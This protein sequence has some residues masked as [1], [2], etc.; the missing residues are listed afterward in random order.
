MAL[1][2]YLLTEEGETIKLIISDTVSVRSYKQEDA[3][4][5]SEIH[6]SWEE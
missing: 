1:P 2:C 5:S 3:P 4:R 6:P